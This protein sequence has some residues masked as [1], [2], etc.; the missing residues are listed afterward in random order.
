[1]VAA[2]VRK[3]LLLV[4]VLVVLAVVT[5]VSM[6]VVV[7]VAE[8]VLVAVRTVAV[9]APAVVVVAVDVAAVEVVVLDPWEYIPWS[10]RHLRLRPVRLPCFLFVEVKLL[11]LLACDTGE[12]YPPAP[13][14]AV[15]WILF[16][17]PLQ[18]YN[19]YHW[20]Y[21]WLSKGLTKK[22]ANFQLSPVRVTGV[23]SHIF[24]PMFISL[25]SWL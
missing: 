15:L 2:D 4:E 11:V 25:A 6:V 3:T 16:Q 10:R 14:V 9:M 17:G 8:V 1:V 24:S 12:A 22:F 13:S 21:V 18:C 23:K 7:L 5:V 20:P 19:K